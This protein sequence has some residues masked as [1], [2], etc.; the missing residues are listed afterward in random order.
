MG[1]RDLD[2]DEH[3]P[4][5]SAEVDVRINEAEGEAFVAAPGEG[6]G[7]VERGAEGAVHA[8]DEDGADAARLH[9]AEHALGTGAVAEA[10]LDGGD[11]GVRFGAVDE[12]FVAVGEAGGGGGLRVKRVDLLR[13]GRADVEKDAVVLGGGLEVAV[14][15]GEGTFSRH[16]KKALSTKH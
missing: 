8:Q 2:L 3:F 9:G 4:D 1:E 12:Q 6:L 14:F 5:G 11:T 10:V 7:E 13:G 16:G 15:S